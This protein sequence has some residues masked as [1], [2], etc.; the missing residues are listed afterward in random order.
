MLTRAASTLDHVLIIFVKNL[1]AKCGTPFCIIKM[2]LN[3]I[4]FDLT[5]TIIS[6]P[7]NPSIRLFANEKMGF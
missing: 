3:Q 6:V 5:S 7:T 1:V 2:L 4:I